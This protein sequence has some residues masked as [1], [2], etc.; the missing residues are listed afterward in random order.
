M[1]LP[2]V[3]ALLPVPVPGCCFE[4]VLQ[5]VVPDPEAWPELPAL[6]RASEPPDLQLPAVAV[7]ADF[8]KLVVAEQL[9]PPAEK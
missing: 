5:S 8:S 1:Q 9:A 3:A 4:Q 7:V 6:P 2:V